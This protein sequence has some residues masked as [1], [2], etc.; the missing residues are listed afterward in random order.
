MLAVS[1]A[2]S[3][4]QRHTMNTLSS[5]TPEEVLN[6]VDMPSA[7]YS[8]ITDLIAERDEFEKDAK[9]AWDQLEE[10]SYEIEV[11]Y[12]NFEAIINNPRFKGNEMLPEL[13][14]LSNELYKQ[15]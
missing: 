2:Y 15:I 4:N 12:N 13:I 8:A 5:Y 9:G 7:A 11:I 14:N 10:R 3:F 6:Y 1:L